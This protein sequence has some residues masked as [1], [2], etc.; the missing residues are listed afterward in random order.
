MKNKVGVDNSTR[1]DST[2]PVAQ[3]P[4][5]TPQKKKTKEKVL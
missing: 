5:P 2:Y 4:L 3:P 1:M